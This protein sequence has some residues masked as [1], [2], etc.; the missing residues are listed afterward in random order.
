MGFASQTNLLG[1]H[2]TGLYLDQQINYQ[3][4][5]DIVAQTPGAQVLDCFSF[6]GG[7]ALH[8][9]RAGAAHV[10]AVDQ[11]A[12]IVAAAT[13]NAAANGLGEKCSF[14]AA[15]VFDWLKVR[16]ITKPHEK[17]VPQF[18]VIVLD[19]PPSPATEPR[20]QTRSAVTRK[21]ISGP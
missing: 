3:R 15:N 11:S 4:V 18:D 16:T 19:P 13:S 7:F 21:S 6:L 20:F 10:H 1:G 8:G 2:K 17:V 9:A 14:E 5:A 12:E